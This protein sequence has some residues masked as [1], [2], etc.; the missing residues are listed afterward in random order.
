VIGL[1]KPLVYCKILDLEI[2]RVEVL[3][4]TLEIGHSFPSCRRAIGPGLAIAGTPAV[5]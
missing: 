2:F 1:L 5:A 4:E 3:G